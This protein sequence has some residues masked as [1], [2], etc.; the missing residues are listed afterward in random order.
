MAVIVIT[1]AL[2]I[3]IIGITAETDNITNLQ[4]LPCCS[5]EDKEN[6]NS[7]LLSMP[8]IGANQFFTY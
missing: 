5:I 8:M 7:Q 3:P 4:Y 1:S 2:A 6:E